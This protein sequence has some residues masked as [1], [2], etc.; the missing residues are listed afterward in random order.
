MA[1]Q[2]QNGEKH[3]VVVG[4]SY[5]GLAMAQEL[6]KL[7]NP[8]RVTVV[9]RNSH[10]AHLFAYPRFAIA[11][12][13]EHKAFVPFSPMLAPP[14]RILRASAV[15]L[16]PAARTLTLD[17]EPREVRY[18][19]LVLATGTVLSPPGTMP[20][21]EK[22]EGVGYL[23]GVQRK[24]R[25]AGEIVI[26]GGGAV[27][28]ACDLAI[29]YPAKRG[30]ITLVQ[31][32]RLMPRFHPAL[33]ELVLKRFEELGVTT[34]LGVRAEMPEGGYEALNERGGGEVRLQDG[35]AV[36]ADYVIHA[37][38]QT[39]NSAL[40]L[41]SLPSAV[42]PSGFLRVSPSHLVAPTSPAESALID[43]RIFALGDIAASGAPKAA[44][45]AVLFQAPLVARNIA[46]VLASAPS[47]APAQLEELQPGPAA[48]HLTLG[49]VE[50]VVFRNPRAEG[51]DEKGEPRWMGEPE[52]IWRDDGREDMGIEGVWERRV[53][54]FVTGPESYHL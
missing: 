2:P 3:V 47:S 4:G 12:G 43:A 9:E 5:V 6:L 21:R 24:L 8:P 27:E 31:S 15:S 48:I 26:V 45:P 7:P 42:L 28:M 20:G 51:V 54:G 16:D 32:R 22:H 49:V 37:L 34:V 38:G 46:A 35:R 13:S 44:R 1:T 29:L 30:H 40:L 17:A 11:P 25:E 18:D 39:P 19:A 23:R 36:K 50:S 10:F 52:V 14:H 41:S 53:P 33:H